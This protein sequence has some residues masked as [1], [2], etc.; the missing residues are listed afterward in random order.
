M[1][2]R[3]KNTLCSVHFTTEIPVLTSGE[4][5]PLVPSGLRPASVNS[6]RSLL[7]ESK[8]ASLALAPSDVSNTFLAASKVTKNDYYNCSLTI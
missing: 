8:S 2:S 5:N 1:K 6:C 7:A 3:L 4:A